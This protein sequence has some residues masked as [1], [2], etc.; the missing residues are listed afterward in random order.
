[1][2]TVKKSGRGGARPGAGRPTG[3]TDKVTIEGLL[4]AIQNKA[5]GKSY[6]EIIA[7]DFQAARTA[8]DNNLT[9]KYH[10]LILNKVAATLTNIEVTDSSEAVANKEAAFLKAIEL[11]QTVAKSK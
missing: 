2:E 5:D 1:M 6:V 8:K 10:N 9:M 11:V 7:E 3:S 4:N